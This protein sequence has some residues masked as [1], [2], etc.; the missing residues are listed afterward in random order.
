MKKGNLVIINANQIVTC[1]GFKGKS[2]TAMSDLNVIE[3]G[4]I[5]V[6]NGVISKVTQ[7]VLDVKEYESKG[8]K[9]IDATERCVLPGFVD[10]H[11][12]LIFGGYREQE[13]NWRL[14]GQG[15]MD[16]M[17]KGGGII[18]SVKSTKNAS[19]EEL[20]K[21][22]IKR[23]NSMTGFGVTTVEGKSGYGL[24]LNTEIKQLEVMKRL[25]EI[26]SLDIV[27]TFLGPHARPAE[28]KTNPDAFIDFMI[29]TVLPVVDEK[30]LAEF[31]DIFC[32]EN[33]FSVEQSRRFLGAAKARGF[34][35]KIHADEIVQLGGAELAAELGACSADHLLQVSDAGVI[36]MRD[37]GVVATILPCTA[38]SLKESYARARNMIDQNL[39]VALA[40]DFNPGS[41]FTESIPLLIAL[42]TNQMGMSIEETITA[43][44]INGAAALDRAD[45]IGSIDVGKN[46][47]IVIHEFPTY[48]FL[49]YHIGVSTVEK[50][51][52]NGVLILD[53]F[54]D[55]PY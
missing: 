35:L 30:G 47:D 17:S 42:A 15:Y 45:R 2:G 7:D 41:C 34:K 33:V 29:D 50:V 26:H 16:I 24:D 10:S 46:A 21:V 49:P 3:N 5:V 39:M 38:F 27:T 28:Y 44:T 1:S 32:E 40:S 8:F 22:G 9:I 23:L 14:Q 11:T 18:N 6:E 20:I 37:A 13:Y 19:E 48:N 4:S 53:K 31:A 52:K 55:Q 51:I 43:L 12:H 25:N 54:N 36:A